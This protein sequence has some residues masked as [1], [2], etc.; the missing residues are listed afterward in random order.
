MND[1]VVFYMQHP[2]VGGSGHKLKCGSISSDKNPCGG[3]N[4]PMANDECQ[5][6]FHP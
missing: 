2:I 3:I 4:N 6:V 5:I 1:S